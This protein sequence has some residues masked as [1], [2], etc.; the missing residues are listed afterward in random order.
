MPALRGD[1]VTAA[2]HDSNGFRRGLPQP[3]DARGGDP[4]RR[5]ASESGSGPYLRNAVGG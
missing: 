2:D 1:F 5:T 4:A 3:A